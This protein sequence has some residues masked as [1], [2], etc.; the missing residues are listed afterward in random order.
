[1]RRKPQLILALPHY[2]YNM[3]CFDPLSIINDNTRVEVRDLRKDFVSRA[4]YRFQT[5]YRSRAS[6]LS[7]AVSLF[8]S[9]AVSL[10]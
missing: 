7:R 5:G 1:M 4:A 9:R 6:C 3:I 10:F 2:L 8:L